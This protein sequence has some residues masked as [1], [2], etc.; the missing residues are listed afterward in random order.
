MKILDLFK[1]GDLITVRFFLV[2]FAAASFLT[3]AC[4]GDKTLSNSPTKTATAS[5]A[6]ASPTPRKL[7]SAD[8]IAAFEKANLEIVSPHPIEKSK[9]AHRVNADFAEEIEG[10]E[11]SIP[12][13]GK[14]MRVRVFS[15]ANAIDA[16]ETTLRQEGTA[17]FFEGSNESKDLSYRHL[18][19][20]NLMVQISR[21][22]PQKKAKL[23]FDAL[24]TVK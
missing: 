1:G 15:Y 4:S 16:F 2:I 24:L 23:Y 14:N 5:G 18:N 10:T 21:Q 20:K 11:F 8:A 22:I 6:T 19:Y 9:D 7:S 17:E 13:A 3:L 12:S